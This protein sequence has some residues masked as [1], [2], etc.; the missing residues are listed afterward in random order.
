VKLAESAVFLKGAG[1]FKKCSKCGMEWNSIEEFLSDPD[2]VLTG[3]QVHFEDLKTG[4]LLFNHNC[5]TTLG[6]T[7]DNFTHLYNGEIFTECMAGTEHCPEL[8]FNKR[9]LN[10]CSQKCECT[11][12]REILQIIKKWPKKN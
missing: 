3:Y 11:Y 8:C 9:N 10:P 1:M 4:L 2:V 12:V 7:V 5:G 6:L